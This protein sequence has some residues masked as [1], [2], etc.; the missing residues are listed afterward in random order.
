MAMQEVKKAPQ[1]QQAEQGEHRRGGSSAL[2][3]NAVKKRV[4]YPPPNAMAAGAVYLREQVGEQSI[5]PDDLQ[6][7]STSGSNGAATVEQQVKERQQHNTPA[8]APQHGRGGENVFDER[9]IDLQRSSGEQAGAPPRARRT[10]VR[11]PRCTRISEPLMLPM[12][13]SAPKE[14]AVRIQL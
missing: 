2:G 6:G 8:P 14:S 12:R 11:G 5:A 7:E 10:T 4:S 13:V 3:R 9:G 1:Q